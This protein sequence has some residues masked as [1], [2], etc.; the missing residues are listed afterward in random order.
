[1]FSHIQFFIIFNF[2]SFIKNIAFVVQMCFTTY[3]P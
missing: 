2:L 3:V 1:M